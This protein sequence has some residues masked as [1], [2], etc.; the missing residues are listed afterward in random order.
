MTAKTRAPQ[1]Y[2]PA[3]V[4]DRLGVC[5]KSVLRWIADRKLHAQRFG[6][7]IRVSEDDLL[8]FIAT[9]RV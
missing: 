9:H 8:A 6:R 7:V 2:S 1:M 3:E 4:A 5:R